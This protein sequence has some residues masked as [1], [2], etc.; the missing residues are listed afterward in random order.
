M[1]NEM[2][3]HNALL[4]ET[5]HN[6]T[7]HNDTQHDDTQHYET[8]H[9]DTKLNEMQHNNTLLNETQHNGTQHNPECNCST[10]LGPYSQPIIF[11][12]TYESG[13]VTVFTTLHFLRFLNISPVS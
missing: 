11:F 8:E 2:Q 1:L 12:I 9:D 5:Q 13:T 6:D 4:K 3:H 7:Q 10:K